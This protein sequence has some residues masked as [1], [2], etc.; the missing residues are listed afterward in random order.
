[1]GMEVPKGKLVSGMLDIL[2]HLPVGTAGLKDIVFQNL[3]M[4]ALMCSTRDLGAAW[5]EAKIRAVKGHPEKF[6]FR[7]NGALG[8]ND[9][10][11]ALLD[12]KIS[13]ANFKKLNALARR[14][15]V[16]V[17]TVVT[18]LLKGEETTTTLSIP[19]KKKSQISTGN[20]IK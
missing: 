16:D 20:G 9:G 8:W 17:D 18:R 1:M 10:P 5:N 12:R 6:V 7:V 2:L 19:S 15:G 4:T 3:G 14:D 13:L 11:V